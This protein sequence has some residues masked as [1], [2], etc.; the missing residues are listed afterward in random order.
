MTKK[1]KEWVAME[2]RNVL[3]HGYDA[4]DATDRCYGIA[5]FVSNSV[6]G[7]GTPEGK[8]LADWWD[9]EALPWFNAA[10]NYE[11]GYG[12]APEKTLFE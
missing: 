2:M 10:K 1:V 4:Y 9:N 6:Y 11:D 3:Y 7:Y 5:M 8:A 12:F